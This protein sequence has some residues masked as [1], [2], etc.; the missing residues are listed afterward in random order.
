MRSI[1]LGISS[2]QVLNL[3]STLQVFDFL[4]LFSNI[5]TSYSQNKFLSF[6]R[7]RNYLTIIDPREQIALPWV[8]FLFPLGYSSQVLLLLQCSSPLVAMTRGCVVFSP[9][10]LIGKMQAESK[11]GKT[12]TSEASCLRFLVIAVATVWAGLPFLHV[13]IHLGYL[14][15]H[16]PLLTSI[17]R[18]YH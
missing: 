15:F 14:P 5:S 16:L 18:T 11:Q 8:Y 2:A 13:C 12:G 10:L 7:Y 4:L 9:C 6:L 17:L 1:T 3:K